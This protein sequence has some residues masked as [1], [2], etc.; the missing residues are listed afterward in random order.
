MLLPGDE[1]D[2][3]SRC[4]ESE[5]EYRSEC[6]IRERVPDQD[7]EAT[8]SENPCAC[9]TQ[10]V[11]KRWHCRSVLGNAMCFEARKYNCAESR[12]GV[13]FKATDLDL[14]VLAACAIPEAAHLGSKV[15]Y[16]VVL[17]T[18]GFQVAPKRRFRSFVPD[19]GEPVAGHA[20]GLQ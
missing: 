14:E 12:D 7:A 16:R 1:R 5:A 15:D 9:S 13:I 17:E 10:A 3:N 6:V 11:L 19:H 2:A 8:Q 4:H 18:T 20:N